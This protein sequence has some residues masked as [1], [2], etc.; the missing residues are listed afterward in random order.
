MELLVTRIVR[1]VF[2]EEPIS[3]QELYGGFWS[4]IYRVNLTSQTIAV[5]TQPKTNSSLHMEHALMQKLHDIG[6]KVPIPIASR[7]YQENK[8]SY[9]VMSFAEGALLEGLWS[10][11]PFAERTQLCHQFIEILKKMGSIVIRGYGPLSPQLQGMFPTL[12]DYVSYQ[13]DKFEKEP[14]KEVFNTHDWCFLVEALMSYCDTLVNSGSHLVHADF[15]LQ[16]LIYHEGEITLIDFGNALGMLPG[17][18]LYRFCRVDRS[19]DMLSQ[20]EIT[21]LN[22]AYKRVNPFYD[23]ERPLFQALLGMRLAPF[24]SNSGNDRLAKHYLNDITAVREH[25]QDIL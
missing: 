3:I 12:K 4:K 1:E 7:A 23:C 19:E 22:T 9:L 18:D 20:S 16:N 5:K 17:F 15:R 25:L 8:V 2:Y 6:I 14:I 13:I 24:L 10:Y 11:L 21:L